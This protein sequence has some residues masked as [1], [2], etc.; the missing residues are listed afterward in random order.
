MIGNPY[1][2]RG[3][4]GL[5]RYLHFGRQ[6]EENPHRVE[7]HVA[8]NMPT[9]DPDVVPS[10]MRATADLSPSVQKP[11]YHLPVSWPRGEEP[12]RDTQLAVADQLVTDLGLAEH[13]YTVIAHN[14]GDCRHIHVVINTVHPE[15]GKVWN[16]WRDVYRIMESLE[17]QE[18]ELG[19]Q[20]VDRPDLEE[21]RS[22]EKDPS[23]RKDASRGEKKRAGRE[24]DTALRKWSEN[25]MRSIRRAINNHFQ[26]AK[27]WQELEARLE[28]HGLFLIRAGQG[29]RISDGS[30]F[31][32][33]SKIGKRAREE[34]LSE[35]FR[36]TW[37]E[38]EVIR[39]LTYR[40]AASL[41]PPDARKPLADREVDDFTDVGT[42]G[43]GEGQRQMSDIASPKDKAE[44]RDQEIVHGVAADGALSDAPGDD[45]RDLDE[46]REDD[47]SELR[48]PRLE[49]D[50]HDGTP[51][52]K[53]LAPPSVPSASDAERAK[54]AA[55]LVDV[56]RTH[57]E[58]EA[59]RARERDVSQDGAN[60]VQLRRRLRAVEFAGT[61]SSEE[62]EAAREH[63]R[64]LFRHMY[65][66]PVAA[67]N[68][69][70]SQLREG[71][72]IDPQAMKPRRGRAWERFWPV[73]RKDFNAIDPYALGK[74]RGWRVWGFAS[75][76]RREAEAAMRQV[77]STYQRTWRLQ[78]R[79]EVHEH[80]WRTLSIQTYELEQR[81]KAG[82]ETL[83]DH[84]QREEKRLSLWQARARAYAM[85]NEADIWQSNLSEEAK[86][87]LA[88][89]HADHLQSARERA[90]KRY[91]EQPP[92][93]PTAPG[94][95]RDAWDRD[96]PFER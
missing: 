4:K 73:R 18:R 13:Q 37:E 47:A 30:H 9:S 63:Y 87:E 91:K 53:E 58:Y 31:M 75:E 61:K 81:Y 85:I 95:E 42:G 68:R 25:D 27:S 70:E 50:S 92:L 62:L 49:S 52:P 17:R 64:G 51:V 35:R 23:R 16:A 46:F 48:S 36:M 45:T 80:D 3:F 24:E 60:L 88:R 15:T 11:V 7:W 74:M 71:K 28:R 77:P 29:F 26:D 69:L 44:D 6:G 33:M 2:G 5:I 83:G 86:A 12:A 94:D 19:L 55:H 34:Q 78:Q 72:E 32:T 89:A 90:R 57:R 56:W 10:I 22:G 66:D 79:L 65:K 82:K 8:R 76:K 39:P 41:E 21:Y 1:K 43:D 59:F 96:D 54:R 93:P 14:D 84:R 40:E 20:I 67:M 38:Y